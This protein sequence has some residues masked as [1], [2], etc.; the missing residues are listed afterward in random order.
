MGYTVEK[1]PI[2]FIITKHF[3]WLLF[4][5]STQQQHTISDIFIERTKRYLKYQLENN[6]PAHKCTHIYNT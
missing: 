2:N 4:C 5:S 6:Q 1:K 3:K